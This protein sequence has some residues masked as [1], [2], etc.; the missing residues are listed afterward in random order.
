M[1]IMKFKSMDELIERG[2]K[3]IYGLAASVFSKDLEKVL[4][5][6]SAIKAGTVW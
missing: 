5:V 3:T 1:Q 4:H 2:N 6:T